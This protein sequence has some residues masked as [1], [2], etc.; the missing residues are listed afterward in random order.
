VLHLALGFPAWRALVRESGL[1][2][3]EAVGAMV[4]AVTCCAGVD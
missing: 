4:Q 2:Q 1:T 3:E